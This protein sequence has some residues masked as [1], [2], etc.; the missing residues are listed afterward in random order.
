MKKL[1]IILLIFSINLNIFSC[2]EK[3]IE[4]EVDE[5]TTYITENIIIGKSSKYE[6]GGLLTIPDN[7]TEE[8]PCPAV[9][10][11]HGSGPSDMDGVPKV[12][13]DYPNKPFLDIAD[14]LS[15]H[16]I[17]VIR[18]DKRTFTHG[19]KMINESGSFTV[20]EETIE[21]AIL[22]AEILKSDS[23]INKNKVFIIGH[24]LG[25]MLAP[26]IHAEGGDFAGIISFAGSP[27]S[28]IE[29][30]RDQSFAANMAIIE[31]LEGEELEE[32]L[33]IM[34]TFDEDWNA[35]WSEYL[36]IS[37]ENEA[38]N[39]IIPGLG[40]CSVYYMQDLG[41]I[42]VSEY[43]KN[44]TVTFLIMQGS[45]DFQ[46]YVDKDYSLWQKLLAGRS[47]ATFKLYEGLN[48]MFMKSTTKDIEEYF[49]VSHV[50]EQVLIDIVEWIKA[51]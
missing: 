40:G 49:I 43:I 5:I 39:T 6:L 8:K 25:G 10:L 37:D 33:I 27:R 24:S 15:T 20:Y 29:I 2:T 30:M 26:R 47:N 16:G 23:R 19:T 22:A 32:A 17:A 36:D 31:T 9:V 34:E 46:V 13:P 50:E 4:P 7:A 1:F 28:L 42:P 35:Y 38:K 41:K 51:N 44:I 14:Y 21:D 11:V 18:Y 48:H 12:Y 3:K 45:A